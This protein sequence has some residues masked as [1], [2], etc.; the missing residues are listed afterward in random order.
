MRQRQRIDPTEAQAEFRMMHQQRA[1]HR[2]ESQATGV[3]YAV[4]P[5]FADGFLK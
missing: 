3:A 2:R 4:I 5:D 1:V